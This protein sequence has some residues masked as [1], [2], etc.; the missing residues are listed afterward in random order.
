M[1]WLSNLWAAL[2]AIGAVLVALFVKEKRDIKK[3]QDKQKQAQQEQHYENIKEADK[4][5]D[6]VKR[7]SDHRD[8]LRER[9]S[10]DK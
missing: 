3:G 6:D 2:A 1:K 7:D 5:R 8:K 4:A 10:R 9:F